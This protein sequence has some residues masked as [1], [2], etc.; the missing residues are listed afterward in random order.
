MLVGRGERSDS[1]H[2]ELFDVSQLQTIEQR[3]KIS[4]SVKRRIF[5]FC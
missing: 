4:A 1:Y 2:M 3:T 5:A